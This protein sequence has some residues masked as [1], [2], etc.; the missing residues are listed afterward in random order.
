MIYINDDNVVNRGHVTQYNSVPLQSRR[1]VRKIKILEVL[2][3]KRLLLKLLPICNC[4]Y[5]MCKWVM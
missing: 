4:K 1:V 3:G 5:W 2:C